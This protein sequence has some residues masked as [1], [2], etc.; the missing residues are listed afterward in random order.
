M[1]REKARFINCI[2]K[3]TDDCAESIENLHNQ[4]LYLIGNSLNTGFKQSNKKFLPVKR[5][6]S[7]SNPCSRV[8]PIPL[9]AARMASSEHFNNRRS[10]SAFSKSPHGSSA[11]NSD[12]DHEINIDKNLGCSMRSSMVYS[13]QTKSKISSLPPIDV[14]SKFPPLPMIDE[15]QLQNDV[16]ASQDSRKLSK[17]S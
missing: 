9:A 16:L 10:F 15:E 13:N 11:K 7:F 4:N 6:S 17:N 2:R 14:K 3:S 8:L 1:K 5:K 12:S